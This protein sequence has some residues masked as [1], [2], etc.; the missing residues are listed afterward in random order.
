MHS[1]GHTRH[2]S[3]QQGSTEDLA[4][5]AYWLGHL[6]AAEH[7]GQ[8]R[9]AAGALAQSTSERLAADAAARSGGLIINTSGWVDGAGYESLL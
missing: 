4:P 7:A 2:A 8:F 5:I 9:R 3:P 1:R 6:S